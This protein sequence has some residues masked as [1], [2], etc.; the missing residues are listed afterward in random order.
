MALTRLS[1]RPAFTLV[2]CFR[3]T[4]NERG[5]A[6]TQILIIPVKLV[7]V[8]VPE[9]P[10]LVAMLVLALTTKQMTAEKLLVHILGSYKMMAKALVIFTD[11]PE[12]S[13][14]TS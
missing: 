11:R 14:K 5:V 13:F 6:F 12:R 1:G 4:A 7:V 9:C 10:P 2:T 8:A 3:S